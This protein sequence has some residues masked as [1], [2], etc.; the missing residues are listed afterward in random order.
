MAFDD[1]SV[2][3]PKDPPKVIF[4]GRKDK[5]LPEEIRRIFGTDP[6]PNSSKPKPPP[7]PPPNSYHKKPKYWQMRGTG[8][9]FI[10]SFI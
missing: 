7:P 4:H 9:Q 2:P 3:P 10:L 1:E 6:P 5:D 8:N